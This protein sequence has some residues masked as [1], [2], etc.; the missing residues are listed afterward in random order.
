[1][2]VCTRETERLY[3]PEVWQEGDVWVLNDS[4]IGGTHLN[5]VTVYRPIFCD[6]EL[7]GFAASI[8]VPSSA[9]VV[10]PRRGGLVVDPLG[11]RPQEVGTRGW[12]PLRRVKTAAVV[13]ARALEVGTD[14]TVPIQPTVPRPPTA[15]AGRNSSS[16]A[17]RPT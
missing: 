9:T 5:D 7:A 6:G 3:G 11:L 13:K 14:D 15:A 8:L 1:M 12:P 2:E 10:P 16:A 17:H 4:Y